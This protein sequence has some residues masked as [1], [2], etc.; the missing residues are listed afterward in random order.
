MRKRGRKGVALL[1]VLWITAA[2]TLIMYAFLGEMQ[3]EYSLSGSYGDEKKAEQLA[4]SAV[5]L[6]CI[7]VDNAVQPWHGPN[8][9]WATNPDRFYEIALGDG[10]FSVLQPTYADD[11]TLQ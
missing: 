2:L 6:A 4:W 3:V 1:V 11:G 5:D 7:T 10:A 9:L 8:D